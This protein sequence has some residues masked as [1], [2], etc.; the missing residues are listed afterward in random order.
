MKK[1][2]SDEWDE[3]DATWKLLGKAAPTEVR[4]RFTDDAVRAVKLLP[5]ADPWFTKVSFFASWAAVAACG[6]F[7]VSFFLNENDRGESSAP[8]VAEVAE[9]QQD[10]ESMEEM[11]DAEMLLAAVDHLDQ[12]S[13]QELVSL[14]GF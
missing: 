6:V 14:I 13:D 1:N 4:S 9:E 3:D 10:W 5:E 7:A 2:S 8:V 12:F 11:A